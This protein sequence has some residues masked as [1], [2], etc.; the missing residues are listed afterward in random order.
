MIASYVDG[1]S[2]NKLSNTGINIKEFYDYCHKALNISFGEYTAVDNLTI[3][4]R[5]NYFMELLINNKQ[6]E[7]ENERKE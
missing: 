7:R 3:Y 5:G 1:R 2:L 6:K 4:S